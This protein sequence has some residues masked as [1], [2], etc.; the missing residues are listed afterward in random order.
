VVFE[1]HGEP[2][3]AGGVYANA[4]AV[5]H[6][7]HEFTLDFMV[8]AQPPQPATMPDGETVIRVQRQLVARVRIPPGVVFEV[9]RAINENMTNYEQVF[10]QIRRP[11]QEAPMYPPHDRGGSGNSAE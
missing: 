4:L 5:W 8:N 7:E 1:L 9:I 6:T 10:G 2:G 3:L 11:G